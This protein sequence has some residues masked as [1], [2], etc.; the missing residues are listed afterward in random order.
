M[1]NFLIVTVTTSN[2]YFF[3]ID[4][5]DLDPSNPIN[6]SLL[7]FDGATTRNTKWPMRNLIQQMQDASLNSDSDTLIIFKQIT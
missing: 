1:T 6:E 3:Y 5:L 2:F 7:S 4:D